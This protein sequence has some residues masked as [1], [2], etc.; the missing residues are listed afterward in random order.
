M[1]I[2]GIIPARYASSRFPGKPLADING[3]AMIL[4][5]YDRA[6]LSGVFKDVVVATDDERILEVVTKAGFNAVMT[7]E[8]HYS[9][10][11]RCLEA[12]DI[13]EKE[14]GSAFDYV[15][16]I[17]GDEPFIDP[18]QIRK[19]A[20][21]LNSRDAQVATLAKLITR[22]EDIFNPNVV[23]VVFGESM[24]ALYFSRSPIPFIRDTEWTTMQSHFKH[25]G[26][27][28]FKTA[29]LRQACML[30]AGKLEKLESLEQLRW[31]ENS[32]NI[33]VGLTDVESIAIDTPEDLLKI[34]NIA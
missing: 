30:P 24:Q 19:V 27:Y 18:Q 28:G 17:Q 14:T 10:T 16:N 25:I 34:T 33:T 20:E 23:K 26:I 5:V 21:L 31:L 3:R 22:R 12:L 15:I 11:D 29:I 32:I 9:G 2:L 4:R 1:N 13:R 6:L 7:S 8:S